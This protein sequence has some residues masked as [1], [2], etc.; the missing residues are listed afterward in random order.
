MKNNN[1]QDIL[2]SLATKYGIKEIEEIDNIEQMQADSYNASEGDLNKADGYNCPLCKNKGFIAK[3]N[4]NCVQVYTHCKCKRIRDALRRA[5]NS[6][7][8]NILSDFTFDK[9]E[10]TEKWQKH[11]KDTALEFCKDS[12]AKW[13][14]IGGQVGSGKSHI[15]TAIAGFYIKEGYDVRYMIWNDESKKLKALITD[16]HEYERLIN[17]YKNVDV[18][19]IDDFLKVRNGEAPTTADINLAFEI[20][21]N[22]LLDGNKITIISSEKPLKDILDYDE[23]TM[24]RIHQKTGKYQITIQKDRSKNYRLRQQ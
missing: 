6:G 12:N 1:L 24:S 22:R 7:L 10:I 8:G 16:A 15:C 11:I 2:L 14:Y 5:K 23:A 21:N 13:F 4:E 18:L 17:Q 9:F 3:V 19:Y 20:I